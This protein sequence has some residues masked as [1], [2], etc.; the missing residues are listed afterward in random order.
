MK[1]IR[2][3]Q[4][5]K[6]ILFSAITVIFLLAA[7][8]PGQATQS[9]ED[10][11]NQISTSV[12]LTV[13][14]QN[15]QTEAAVPIPTNTTLPTQTEVVPPTETPII[16]TATPFVIVPPTTVSSGGGGGGGTV[17]KPALDCTPINNVPR[18]NTVFHKNDT[19]DIKWTLLNTGTKTI[20]AKLDVKYFSGPNMTP[21]QGPIE[22]PDIKPGGTFVIDLDGH[23]PAKKGFHVMTWVVEGNLCYPY[24][25]IIVE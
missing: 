16:P 10:I 24:I 20:P 22:T 17:I 9:P 13:A 15:A 19:F 14:A 8:L 11:A 25:A 2:M 21:G 4:Y 5:P 12:A 3:T 23:A 7:C 6:R 18:D 1:E